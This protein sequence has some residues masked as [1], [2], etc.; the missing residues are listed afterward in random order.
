MIKPVLYRV[1]LE[2]PIK[3]PIMVVP[4]END[5]HFFVG[6]RERGGTRTAGDRWESNLPIASP[7]AANRSTLCPAMRL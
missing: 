3:P 2:S 7:G 6:N 1:L 4:L 5:R